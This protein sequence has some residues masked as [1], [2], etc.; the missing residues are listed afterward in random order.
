MHYP[1]NAPPRNNPR[2][3]RWRA[4]F[5][6]VIAFLLTVALIACSGSESFQGTELT[7]A[8]LATPFELEN[9]FGQSVS[10][11]DYRGKVVLLTFLYTNCPDVCPIVTSQIRDAYEMLG[12]DTEEAA[13]IAV[14]VDPERDS[15]EAA[16]AYSQQWDMLHSWD[17]LVGN[18]E[19]LSP[20]WQAYYIDPVIDERPVGDDVSG[21]DEEHHQGDG[22]KALRQEVIDRYLVSHSAPVYLIDRE[23][24]MRVIFTLPFEPE[25]V[26]HD[27]RLLLD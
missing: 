7:S 16:H 12:K 14:S 27:I 11:S 26:A 5:I 8:S 3:R 4:G 22:G 17:F 9:Q 18:R 6:G 19:R 21:R 10:L 15:L 2:R 20:I 25:A 1:L 24:I 23:G 13:F